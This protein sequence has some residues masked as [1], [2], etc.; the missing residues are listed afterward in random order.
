MK[1]SDILKGVLKNII[2]W[3]DISLPTGLTDYYTDHQ[4]H[5]AN[6]TRTVDNKLINQGVETTD[7]YYYNTDQE[8]TLS[9]IVIEIYN[10]YSYIP[11]VN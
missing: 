6:N 9:N 1:L 2:V 4:E 8:S 11:C 3:L 5:T 10:N 7:V